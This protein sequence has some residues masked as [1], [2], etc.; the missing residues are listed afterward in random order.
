MIA[1]KPPPPRLP[2]IPDGVLFDALPPP[3]QLALAEVVTPLFQEEVLEATSALARSAG[4]TLVHAVWLEVVTQVDLARERRRV[5]QRCIRLRVLDT[6]LV[7]Q[8]YPTGQ[9]DA[10]EVEFRIDPGRFQAVFAAD[11]PREQAAVLAATQRPAAALAFTEPSGAPAWARSFSRSRAGPSCQP[12][13]GSSRTWSLGPW[14][15]CS[16]SWRCCPG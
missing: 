10:S 4:Y 2:W 15:R 3:L 8:P 7:P 13:R 12:A 11:L 16:C 6:A 5:V 9:G 1:A 14:A